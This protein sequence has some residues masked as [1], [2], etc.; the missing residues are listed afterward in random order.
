[1]NKLII[2]TPSYRVKKLPK[3]LKSINFNYISEW[4]IV[5]DGSKIDENFKQFNNHNKI[6]ELFFRSNNNEVQGNA[7]R[8]LGLNYIDKKYPNENMF[9]Y[10][11]DDD[12]IIHPRFMNL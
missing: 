5:Y 3:I 9:V 10:F 7:Q 1:M 8:N 2:I 12:N 11:L 6:V 4:I